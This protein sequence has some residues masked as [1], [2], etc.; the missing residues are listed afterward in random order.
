MF[1]AREEKG[2]VLETAMGPRA[3]RQGHGDAWTRLGRNLERDWGI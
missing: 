1:S 2:G 3:K